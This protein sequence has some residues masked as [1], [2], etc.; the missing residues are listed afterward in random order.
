MRTMTQEC[1]VGASRYSDF[2]IIVSRKG[3]GLDT[4]LPMAVVDVSVVKHHAT[5]IAN[6]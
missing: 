4:F 6:T 2:L 5:F 1:A 3:R